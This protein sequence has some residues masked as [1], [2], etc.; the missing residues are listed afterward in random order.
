MKN[1][2]YKF[3]IHGSIGSPKIAEAQIE[4]S[5]RYRYDCYV[6]EVKPNP[7]DIRTESIIYKIGSGEMAIYFSNFILYQDCQ[8]YQGNYIINAD[9]ALAETLNLSQM[10]NSLI[11]INTNN[12]KLGFNP[13]HKLNITLDVQNPN[14]TEPIKGL[15]EIPIKFVAVNNGPPSFVRPLPNIYVAQWTSLDYEFPDTQDFDNDQTILFDIQLNQVAPFVKGQY[16]KF[17]ISPTNLTLTGDY[18]IKLTLAD[19]NP[20]QLFQK[21]ELKIIVTKTETKIEYDTDIFITD[22]NLISTDFKAKIKSIDM[23]GKAKIQFNKDIKVPQNYWKFNEKVLQIQII[24]YEDYIKTD[25]KFTWEVTEFNS[26]TMTIQLTFE[27]P[28]KVSA[29]ISFVLIFVE[30]NKCGLI[31][32]SYT[33]DQL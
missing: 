14:E 13:L 10:Y 4:I 9:N 30:F 21:Y 29:S 31:A 28:R 11:I 20:S 17:R 18:K 25:L 32:C 23:Q 22:Q 1:K 6:S 5:I 19:D 27:D 24:D 33:A 8:S 26:N 12:K 15:L 16:P 2:G 3:Y 7:K